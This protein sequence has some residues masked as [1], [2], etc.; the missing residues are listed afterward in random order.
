MVDEFEEQKK[1]WY[2]ELA[3]IEDKIEEANLRLDLIHEELD[4]ELKKVNELNKGE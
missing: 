2:K 4:A 1:L 3:D